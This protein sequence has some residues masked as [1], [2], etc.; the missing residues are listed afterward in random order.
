MA[1]G[2]RLVAEY[3]LESGVDTLGRWLVHHIAELIQ[4]A[5][6]AT[7]ADIA[8]RRAAA[9]NA[10]LKFW[11]HRRSLDRIDPLR[12]LKPLLGVIR[13]LNPDENRW[14]LHSQDGSTALCDLYSAIR[15]IIVFLLLD[16]APSAQVEQ[17]KF[18]SDEEA[19]II[20]A[21]NIW[22]AE[23]Q[24]EALKAKPKPRPRKRQA[25]ANNFDPKTYVL[26]EI[27]DARR[28]LDA[29]EREVRGLAPI[30]K[31]N[32]YELLINERLP[33]IRIITV[34]SNEDQDD[35]SEL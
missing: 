31:P 26:S 30:P 2:K 20:G 25:E 14:S 5:E 35:N 32:P 11:E 29:L 6:E 19:E 3:E 34:P 13:T 8:D 22:L 21:L 12:D 23:Y 28:A 7:S 9:A 4:D 33:Q 24:K 15:Q 27:D 1:F 16:K 18:L 17:S 10:I